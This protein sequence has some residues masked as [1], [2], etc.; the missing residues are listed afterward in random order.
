M[1]LFKKLSQEIGNEYFVRVSKLEIKLGKRKSKLLEAKIQRTSEDV[2][3][4]VLKK[5]KDSLKIYEWKCTG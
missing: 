1:L 2:K 5:E 4:I 3:R